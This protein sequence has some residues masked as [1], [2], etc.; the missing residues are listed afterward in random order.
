MG[1]VSSYTFL[2][3][4]KAA[5]EQHVRP[6]LDQL[7]QPVVRPVQKREPQLVRLRHDLDA[8]EELYHDYKN[9]NTLSA[10][11]QVSFE[12][13]FDKIRRK[14]REKELTDPSP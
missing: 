1:I 6:F 12:R 4:A 8:L 13:L 9:R 14:I 2:T 10:D 5:K 7:P 3:L 11:A